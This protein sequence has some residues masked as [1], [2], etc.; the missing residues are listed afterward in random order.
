MK[1]FLQEIDYKR[2]SIVSLILVNV[3]LLALA[4]IQQWSVFMVVFVFWIENVIIGFFNILKMLKAQPAPVDPAKA[5]G[6]EVMLNNTG[7]GKYFF[8]FFFMIHYYAFC[9]GHVVFIFVLF[10]GDLFGG[11]KG[12]MEMADWINIGIGAVGI[13]ISHAISFGTN[14]IGKKEYENVNL[15]SLMM[16]PYK[17]IVLVHVFIIGAGFVLTSGEG[18]SWL[19]LALFMIGKTII[20]LRQHYKEHEAASKKVTQS[21]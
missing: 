20:D 21:F 2:P 11:I 10:L 17:R 16:S 13:F 14:Y 5:E 6:A 3:V 8:A 1:I 18:V 9:A 4:L 7:C 12:H 19:L 15:K